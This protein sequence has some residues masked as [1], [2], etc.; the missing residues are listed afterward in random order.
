MNL[1]KSLL[2]TAF[3]ILALSGC[4]DESS[5]SNPNKVYKISSIF[6]LKIGDKGP[7]LPTGYLEDNKAFDFTPDSIHKYFV[8]YTFSVTPNTQRIYGIKM[9]SD[10]ELLTASCKEQRI[11]VINETLAALGDT[12][13][14]KINEEG[15]QW[16][17]REDNQRS[18]TINC[19]QT[20]KATT[21]QLVMTYTDT[22]LSKVSYVEWS[23]HQDDITKPQ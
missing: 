7:G 8:S 20:L 14:L 6:G 4:S 18:I 11:E 9:K 16:K 1:F 15:N 21:R 17:I 22:P 12:S 3:L 23:K 2:L 5:T 13:M 10:K 19:E